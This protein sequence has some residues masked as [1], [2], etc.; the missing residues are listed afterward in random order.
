MF[1]T[2]SSHIDFS[3]GPVW[4][5]IIAQ[6]LPLMLANLVQLLYNVVDRIYIGHMD[7]GES[8]ALTGVGITF[9]IVTFI[10]AFAAL[11]GMGGTPLFSMAN[12]GGNNERAERILG[13]SVKL[14]LTCAVCLIIVGYAFMKPILYVLGASDDSY[15]YASAYLRV[16]LAGTVFSMLTTG[17]NGYINAQGYPKVGMLTIIIG[18]VINVILDPIC[19]FL[20]GLG[21]S[22]AALATVISQAVS[23]AWIMYFLIKKAPLRLIR[24][25]IRF[26]R[27]ITRSICSLGTSNFVMTGTT[28]FVQAACNSTLKIYGGDLF[29][30]I[31]TVLN[32]IRDIFMLPIHGLVSGA[33][34]VMSFN[35]GAKSYE[36]VR[37][38]IKF[39]TLAGIVYTVTAWLFIVLFPK[40]WFS[41]FTSDAEMI[42]TGIRSLRIY[43][44]GFVF[45]SL[46]FAGQ[47][48][49]QALD[50]P[51]HAIFFSLL[52][53]AVIVIPLTIIL[54]RFGL[55][56]DGVFIAEPIS[57]AIGGIACYLTM[58][59]TVYKGLT[60]RCLS[61]ES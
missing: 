46:Q 21:V 3:K 11:F 17:L 19:I 55:G 39:N 37:S 53:K 31:M 40:F 51:K 2:K 52:R 38:A 28:C 44:F 8:T 13:N 61:G 6:A 56:S 54:P 9:P 57:N 12:G 18:A 49:F 4:R 27:E 16:Y 23:A 25:N 30:G 5:I 26:D 43:F 32:S 35:Y 42:T 29:I 33:Q 59:R 50:D 41:V 20:L 34:P 48:A 60:G 7:G 1:E 58:R 24:N 15:I 14:L 10:T 47:S 22:G 36:R 45:M